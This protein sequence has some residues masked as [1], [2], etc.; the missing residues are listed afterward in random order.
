MR[1]RRYYVAP[2]I[3][4]KRVLD[5]GSAGFKKTNSFFWFVRSE[6]SNVLGLE[7]DKALAQRYAADGIIH[8]DAETY[9]SPGT[10][11]VVLGGELV[12]HLSNVGLFLDASRKNLTKG[13]K[14]VLTTP[15][16]YSAQNVL[17]S[18]VFGKEAKCK[19]HTALHSE[20]TLKEVLTRHGYGQIQVHYAHRDG[21]MRLRA[22][23]EALLCTLKP[24]WRPTLVVIAS[25]D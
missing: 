5:I 2:H 22:L 24:S 17:R 14:L 18:L 8:G 25:R 10:F 6:A 11:D 12:E 23:L 3:R 21:A 13:G 9:L 1:N 15:N 4:G 19:E 20:T 16:P 7:Y